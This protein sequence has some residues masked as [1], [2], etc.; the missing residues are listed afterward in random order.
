MYYNFYILFS[1]SFF[2][3][4]ILLFIYADIR[5]SKS[6]SGHAFTCKIISKNI[7]RNSAQMN[8]NF[9][10][11]IHELWKLIADCFSVMT[12]KG[13]KKQWKRQKLKFIE[14]WSLDNFICW[15]NWP[16]KAKN[17]HWAFLLPQFRTPLAFW[18][19]IKI[20]DA[21]FSSPFSH[22]CHQ[23]SDSII[24]LKDYSFKYQIPKYLN[25]KKTLFISLFSCF[26]SY[27]FAVYRK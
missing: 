21:T 22:M 26:I 13:S 17:I 1:W 19:K 15:L 6:R 8:Y 9:L 18:L 10:Y 7:Q 5:W 12:V 11:H 25:S 14:I 24:S 3:W 2:L 23:M 27:M 4:F 20:T 16:L